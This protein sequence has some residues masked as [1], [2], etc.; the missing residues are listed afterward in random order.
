MGAPWVALILGLTHPATV[1][2]EMGQPLP[3][4]AWI[5]LTCLLPMGLRFRL[6]RLEGRSGALSWT[7]PLG[8]A[9]L[10]AVLFRALFSVRSTWK[11]RTF[12]DGKAVSANKSGG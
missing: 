11:G 8:N 6:E 3:W 7:Q 4:L 5:G 2:M 1:L 9:V 12:H 10:A